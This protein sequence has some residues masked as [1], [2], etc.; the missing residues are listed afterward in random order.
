MIHTDDISWDVICHVV[1][2]LI[3]K[4]SV[5]G[6]KHRQ[7]RAHNFHGDLLFYLIRNSFGNSFGTR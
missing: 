7:V 6:P 3:K 2:K 1:Y 4:Y 5:Q